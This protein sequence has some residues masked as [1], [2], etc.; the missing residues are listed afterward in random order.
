MILQYLFFFPM[1][2][3][4]STFYG[5]NDHEADWAQAFV[6][7]AEDD[8]GAMKPH[9]VAYAS[10]D[11]KGDDLRRRWDD[12]L[13]EKVG[14]HPVIFA[15]AGSHASYFEQGE[16]LMGAT[17]K[18]LQPVKQTLLRLRR[19]WVETLGQGQGEVAGA[20]KCIGQTKLVADVGFPGR[21]QSCLR[22]LSSTV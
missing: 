13:L 4:R 17:P 14:T 20:G 6:F 16:Y 5:I 11:F 3:W 21:C 1:N 9:W 19:F 22:C 8:T 12:P 10:H 2:D 15:G 18:F 7:L